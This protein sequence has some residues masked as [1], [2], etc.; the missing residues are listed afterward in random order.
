[1]QNDQTIKNIFQAVQNELLKSDSK[2]VY[3]YSD[4]QKL[5]IAIGEENIKLD[6][7]FG[8]M[9]P[10][11]CIIQD[12]DADIET[13]LYV[14]HESLIMQQLHKIFSDNG[15]EL[16]EIVYNDPHCCQGNE[17]VIYLKLI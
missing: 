3:R 17:I 11:N 1:M 5:A 14:P 8:I 12:C 9:S 13:H 2:H 15:Y 10:N 4:D 16:I 7:V 6:F